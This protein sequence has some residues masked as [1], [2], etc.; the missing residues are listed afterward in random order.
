M[1]PYNIVYLRSPAIGSNKK[2]QPI[3]CI[4][5]D[6]P[7]GTSIRWQMSIQNPL[8]KFSR[9]RARAI[10]TGRFTEKPRYSTLNNPNDKH[11]VF[12]AILASIVA[13]HNAP[14]RARKAAQYWLNKNPQAV[15]LPETE[16][17]VEGQ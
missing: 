12:R 16:F 5:F 13:D 6:N 15:E 4:V 11:E 8:D 7:V 1:K 2:G 10:A 17:V 9:E 14:T 3:G